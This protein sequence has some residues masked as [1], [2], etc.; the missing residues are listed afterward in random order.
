[1]CATQTQYNNILFKAQ[2]GPWPTILWYN[3]TMP[4]GTLYVYQTPGASYELHLFTD[5]ILDNLTLTQTFVMPQGYARAL[6]WNLAKEISAEYGFP[7]SPTINKMA[8]ESLAYVKALNALP[9]ERASYDHALLSG[10]RA[11]G[12]WII[13]GGYR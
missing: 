13:H 12:G 7:V 6:K 1:V 4:Y 3:E 10:D 2:P 5:T 8:A 11:D 9:A